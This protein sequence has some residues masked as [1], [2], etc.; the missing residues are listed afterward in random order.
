M[1]LSSVDLSGFIPADPASSFDHADEKKRKPGYM[2]YEGSM[3]Q[4]GTVLQD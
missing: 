4:P 1:K 3:T 2:T